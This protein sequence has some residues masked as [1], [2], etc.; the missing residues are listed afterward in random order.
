VATTT[1]FGWTTPDNTG[2]VKDGALAIRT[3]G[4]AIDTSMVDL[5]GGTTGQ[6]LKKTSGTDMDF[7]W[8][9]QQSWTSLASGS[10]STGTLSLTSISGN[11]KNL[12][13]IMSNVQ[14]STNANIQIRINNLSGMYY[15]RVAFFNDV[16]TGTVVGNGNQTE[17]ITS[18]NTS[19]KNAINSVGNL[20]VDFPNYTN[21]T[22]SKTMQMT[23]VY[24]NSSTS[25]DNTLWAVGMNNESTAAI[26]RI[27]AILSTGTYSTGTYILYG[28]N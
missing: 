23:S 6:I 24:I 14:I 27:D 10:L 20:L 28:G 7:E 26:T 15:E 12:R 2:Y 9:A 19:V 18:G 1:N 13:L 4:S 11:Y 21:T 25:E 17:W 16:N 3:L 22:T 5:K 8:V